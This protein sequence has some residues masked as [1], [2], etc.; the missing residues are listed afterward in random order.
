MVEEKDETLVVE[1]DGEL[2]RL[3]SLELTFGDVLEAQSKA[4][5]SSSADKDDYAKRH[6]V[7]WMVRKIFSKNNIDI[8]VEWLKDVPI[9]EMDRVLEQIGM[10]KSRQ[11]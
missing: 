9:K 6:E 5:I 4:R 8:D 10:R 1:L 7:F 2:F 11:G 3:N